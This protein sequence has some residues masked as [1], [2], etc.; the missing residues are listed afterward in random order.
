MFEFTDEDVRKIKIEYP[1]GTMVR[2]V[3]MDD[4]QAPPTG[5]IGVVSNVDDTGTVFV[6]WDNGS[7]LG[8]VLSEDIIE[9]I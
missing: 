4:L 2:L 8:V 1:N 9:K 3:R 5:T 6:H 7:G